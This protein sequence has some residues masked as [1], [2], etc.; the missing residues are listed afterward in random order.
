MR[1]KAHGLKIWVSLDETTDVEGRYVACFVLGILGIEEERSKCYVGNVAE[2]ER[3]NH[4]SISAFFKN[5]LH[6]LR[7]EQILYNNVLLVCTDAAAYMIHAM[8]NFEGLYSKMI[9]VTCVA[10]S[11]E[12]LNV[13]FCT[14]IETVMDF[15]VFL[16]YYL[17]CIYT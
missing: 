8:G 14:T 6:L 15:V 12:N 9:H 1:R 17:L 4:I 13:Y 2:L 7:P 5:S 3:V 10:F 11:Y 16:L